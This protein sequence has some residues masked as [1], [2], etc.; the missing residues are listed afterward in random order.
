MTD[1]PK[2][3]GAPEVRDLAELKA[4]LLE[5]EETLSAIR[6]GDVD[7]VVVGGPLGQQVYTLENA[8]RPY[9]VLIEQMQEGAVTLG[10]DCTILYCNQRFASIVRTPHEKVIGNSILTFICERDR[11]TVHDLLIGRTG[12]P[13][14]DE[15]TIHAADGTLVPVNISLVDLNVGDGILGV[16]CGVVTD[17][18]QNRRRSDELAAAN[19][20]L[21]REIKER[22]RVEDSLS[23]ALQAAGMG[24][25]DLDL[26]SK[27][28]WR[29]L[30]HDQIFG[31]KSLQPHWT[32]EF[33]LDRFVNEDRQAVKKAFDLAE[34]GGSLEFERRIVRAGDGATRWVHMKGHT[35]YHAG[36]PVRIAGVISDITDRRMVEE[37]LRQAQKMEAVGQLTGGIAHDFNNLLMI[38]GGSLDLLV[39]GAF[40]PCTAAAVDLRL[41]PDERPEF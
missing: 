2:Y 19:A 14:S 32:L 25:W 38:I 1:L 27:T 41:W 31:Y 39:S 26:A 13:V 11:D 28:L 3:Q 33:S 37:Q 34:M 17:L 6:N 40:P 24:S 29:S 20:R 12:R 18:T 30:K 5:A 23:V 10:D 4:R 21:G 15:F 36:L 35:Y 22:I 9:R 16:M 7:A 8:D